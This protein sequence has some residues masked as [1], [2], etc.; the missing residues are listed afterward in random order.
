MPNENNDSLAT[1]YYIV[2]ADWDLIGAW[3]E[4]SKSCDTSPSDLN[5]MVEF[6]RTLQ[7]YDKDR[8]PD[9]MFRICRIEKT[10]VE[11]P[12]KADEGEAK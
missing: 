3:K 5:C 1:A 12:A 10:L 4:A 9:K 6:I 2:E 8:Y 11:L 7:G